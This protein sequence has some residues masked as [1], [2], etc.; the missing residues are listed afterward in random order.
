MRNHTLTDNP[1]QGPQCHHAQGRRRPQEAGY[2]RAHILRSV[3]GGIADGV[4]VCSAAGQLL[5]FNPAAKRILGVSFTHVPLDEWS[6]HYGCYLP[7]TVTPYPPQQLPLAR[8]IR[9]E[10]V[11]RALL[12]LRNPSRPEGAWLSVNARPLK[13]EQG[14][15]RCG[16]AIFRDVTEP[17]RAEPAAFDRAATAR[18]RC[19]RVLLAEDNPVNQR[20]AVRLLEKQGHEVVV[21]GNGREALAALER[22]AFDLV[23]MD[24]QMPEMDGLEATAAIRRREAE[25]GRRLPILALTASA[26][27]GDRER[28]LQAGMDGYL[29]KPIR[30]EEFVQAIEAVV[31]P[32]EPAPQAG[33]SQ[34]AGVDIDLGGALAGMGGD[35]RLLGELT[36]LFLEEYPQAA[37]GTPRGH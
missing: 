16:V 7:D 3:L 27:K 12:F 26:L 31:Q 14:V 36:S 28:F 23:L 2:E 24:V 19:L 10:V 33:A 22:Q 20:L 34:L 11:E 17:R 32:A 30:A 18:R 35:R 4:F 21:A 8:A 6:R 25:T 29:S 1:T 37:G 5:L 9:G 15:I 13:D